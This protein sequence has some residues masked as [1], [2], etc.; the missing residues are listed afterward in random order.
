MPAI[1]E[2]AGRADLKTTHGRSR[3]DGMMELEKAERKSLYSKKW[4]MKRRQ[5]M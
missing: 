5:N 1:Q 4:R 3:L 2:L